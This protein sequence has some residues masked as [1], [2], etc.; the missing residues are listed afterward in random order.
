MLFPLLDTPGLPLTI[1][2]LRESR[3]LAASRPRH[4]PP[5]GRSQAPPLQNA[6]A[7]DARMRPQLEEAVKSER[8]DEATRLRVL[9]KEVGKPPLRRKVCAWRECTR[10]HVLVACA[11]ACADA[12]ACACACANIEA[13]I[14]Y[15]PPED[16][17]TDLCLAAA[18]ALQR[19]GGYRVACSQNSLI[20][21]AI[22][23]K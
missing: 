17:R 2:L 15:I 14:I 3:A 19:E 21:R 11:C 12:C 4:L 18:V 20:L 1:L 7:D 16:A 13:R 23:R 8:Y 22:S 6:D 9:M 10:A 5:P